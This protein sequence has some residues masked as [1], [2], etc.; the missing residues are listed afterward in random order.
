MAFVLADRVKETTTTTGTGAL[1]LDGTLSGFLSFSSAIGNSNTTYYAVVHRTA[2]EWE[3]G[4]GTVSA[5]VLARTTVISSSNT[6]AAVSF[7]AGTKD[8]FVTLPGTKALSLDSV[9]N[10][11]AKTTPVDADELPIVDSAS[12]FSLMKITWANLKSNILDYL[13][14][15]FG[16]PS[17]NLI[18]NGNCTIS[19]ENGTSAVTLPANTYVYALDIFV[20]Q[21]SGA[22]TTFAQVDVP[23]NAPSGC[24]KGLQILGA[25]GVTNPQMGI[26]LE[27]SFTKH[28]AGKSVVFSLDVYNGSGGSLAFSASIYQANST[29]NFS[30]ITLDTTL[31]CSITTLPAGW[32]R[33]ICTGTLTA[34]ATTGLWI[35]FVATGNL[36]AASSIA[37]TGFDFYGGTKE[38][39]FKL[40][41]DELIRVKRYLPVFETSGDQQVMGLCSNYDTT[42]AFFILPLDV[43]TRSRVTGVTANAANAIAIVVPGG[44]TMTSTAIAFNGSSLTAIEVMITVASG[45]PTGIVRSNGAAKLIFTGARL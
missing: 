24:V 29:D 27:S 11:A 3:V 38:R 25:T 17:E 5:G 10:A 6:N 2:E 41:T 19:R 35:A 30:G 18:P 23:A 8:V 32:S 36:P 1:T 20:A 26:K 43:I 37:F 9:H 13:A 33:V 42:R 22:G 7:S 14:T 15:Y 34:A 28:L 44:S 16:H 12:G 45:S 40:G 21:V 4:I 39:P 31:T